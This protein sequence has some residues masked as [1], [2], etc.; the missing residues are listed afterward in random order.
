MKIMLT[1]YLRLI[2]RIS[3]YLYEDNNNRELLLCCYI[4][5]INNDFYFSTPPLILMENTTNVSDDDLEAQITI[6]YDSISFAPTVIIPAVGIMPWDATKYGE[7]GSGSLVYVPIHSTQITINHNTYDLIDEEPTIKDLIDV[8]KCW[9]TTLQVASITEPL[10]VIKSR[11]DITVAWLN[12]MDDERRQRDQQQVAAANTSVLQRIH[13]KRLKGNDY[14]W[15]TVMK[16][17]ALIAAGN[18]LSNLSDAERAKRLTIG[19]ITGKYHDKA[20]QIRGLD[21]DNFLRMRAAFIRIIIESPLPSTYV[22]SQ[23]VSVI[24]RENTADVLRQS[25]IK[26]AVEACQSQYEWV[27]VF[28]IIGEGALVTRTNASLINP[29]LVQIKGVARVAQVMDSESLV[30]QGNV[31]EIPLG[32]GPSDRINAVIP[33]FHACD[34]P[35]SPFIASELFK[36]LVHFQLMNN[37]DT[38]DANSY[39]AALSTLWCYYVTLPA[40]EFRTERLQMVVDTTRLSYGNF[41]N[42]L[43]FYELV[44]AG[45]AR[46]LVS[47]H[48]DNIYQGM[49]IRCENLNKVFLAAATVSRPIHGSSVAE[50]ATRIICE[51]FSRALPPDASFASFFDYQDCQAAEDIIA[52]QYATQIKSLDFETVRQLKKH[53]ETVSRSYVPNVSRCTLA[54]EKLQRL[55]YYNLSFPG[56]IAALTQLY[57]SQIVD[58]ITTPAE[59]TRALYIAIK[60]PN[61]Y[62]RNSKPLVDMLDKQEENMIQA[63]IEYRAAHFRK[64]FYDSHVPAIVSH[65]MHR[66]SEQHI[67]ILPLSRAEIRLYCLERGIDP[68]QLHR[69]RSGLLRNACASRDCPYFMKP[70]A[71]LSEHLIEGLGHRSTPGFHVA[72]LAEPTAPMEKVFHDIASGAFLQGGRDT[73]ENDE[74]QQQ[75]QSFTQT[76]QSEHE[77]LFLARVATQAYQGWS[78]ADRRELEEDSYLDPSS[79]KGRRK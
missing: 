49:S 74:I 26:E 3:I 32:D 69:S 46:T 76:Y 34:A 63:L 62:E 61:S 73:R 68:T 2:I 42:W 64:V 50:F 19:T 14:A 75:L 66:F 13:A 72:M 17:V 8:A 21:V 79:L 57:G 51:F 39:L 11:A 36:L 5:L 70:T 43:A 15:N 45:D 28:P 25:D 7:V 10:S 54:V 1:L 16:E 33:L 20:M 56:V 31:I 58:A 53:A 35:L 18:V 55:K 27:E 40:S 59:L 22:C 77:T 4:A 44:A 30:L 41:K 24:S 9:T 60:V 47:D 48:P 37:V 29:F 67:N 65:Y 52:V 38:F 71:Q 6:L 78:D 23:I 12:K